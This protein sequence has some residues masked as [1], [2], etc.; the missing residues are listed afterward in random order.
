MLKHGNM[1][2][3]QDAVFVDGDVM[4]QWW[5]NDDGQSTLIKPV[6]SKCFFMW[7]LAFGW[8][9]GLDDGAHKEFMEDFVSWN[10]APPI[11][12]RHVSETFDQWIA[13]LIFLLKER[14]KLDVSMV[15]DNI[16]DNL[17][18]T[19]F[20]GQVPKKIIEFNLISHVIW[21]WLMDRETNVQSIEEMLF[22][23]VN[24]SEVDPELEQFVFDYCIERIENSQDPD[25]KGD[26]EPSDELNDLMGSSFRDVTNTEEFLVSLTRSFIPF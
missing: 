9:D 14:A 26:V 19:M 21:K 8:D 17:P 20:K 25:T 11:H 18:Q 7:C 13:Y 3:V 1:I 4:C 15:E 6:V 22:K 23:Y 10:E 5:D 16:N 2:M 12:L 24:G